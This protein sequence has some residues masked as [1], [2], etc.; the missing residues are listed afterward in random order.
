M[1]NLNS[2][3]EPVVMTSIGRC[4]KRK[5]E[6]TARAITKKGR[7]CALGKIP[8]T[9]CI[10]NNSMCMASTLSAEEIADIHGRLYTQPVKTK[11]DSTLL[12]I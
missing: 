9:A 7:H 6:E 10:H 1:E 4:K 12:L 11:Q 3:D 5:P 8:G 2:M